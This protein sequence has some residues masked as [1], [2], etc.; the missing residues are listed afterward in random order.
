MGGGAAFMRSMYGRSDRV[1]QFASEGFSSTQAALPSGHLAPSAWLLPQVAG[2]MASRN[3]AVMALTVS[4]SGTQGILVSGSTSMALAASG[5]G[6]AIANAS[7]IATMAMAVSALPMSAILNG[8]GQ[9]FMALTASGTLSGLGSM[10][11]ASAMALSASMIT[12]AIGTMVMAPISQDLTAASIASAVWE[13]T[14]SANNNAG[15]MGEKLN[16]AGAAGNPWAADTT[17][18]QTAGT[19]GKLVQDTNQNAKL[20]PATL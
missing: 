18:N 15:T 14:A 1:N 12:G 6:A 2:G 10:S 13:A 19:F 7:G 5:S 17:D 16:D 4:G 11:G 3:E 9:A 8:S 20:I